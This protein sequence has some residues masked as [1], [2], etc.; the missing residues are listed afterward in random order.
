MA[1]NPSIIAYATITIADTAGTIIGLGSITK[2]G[3]MKSFV[4]RLETAQVRARGDGT[5]PTTTEGEV[6][7]AGDAVYLSEG[8]LE[9][10]Q[11][12]RTG[13]TSGVLKGH[14]YNVELDVLLGARA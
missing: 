12:I 13:A 2:T 10:M 1:R 3:A 14:F 9:N 4:G 7:N 8:D 11:L 5:A 6:V